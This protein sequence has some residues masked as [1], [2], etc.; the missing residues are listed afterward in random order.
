M[1]LQKASRRLSNL[2]PASLAAIVREEG[3]VLVRQLQRALQHDGCL[4]QARRGADLGLVPEGAPGAESDPEP[5][6]REAARVDGDGPGLVLGRRCSAKQ[7]LVA[8]PRVHEELSIL[9]GVHKN[10][11]TLAPFK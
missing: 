9:P 5:P 3:R 1:I 4:A 7:A 2:D 6:R 10:M 11:V 8:G